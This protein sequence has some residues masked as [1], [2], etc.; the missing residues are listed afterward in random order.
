MHTASQY[1]ETLGCSRKKRFNLSV[2]ERG[3]GRTR[4][5]YF[6][7]YGFRVHKGFGMSYNVKISD[8]SECW[9]KSWAREMKK[10]Y[11]RCHSS[12]R[13]FKLVGGI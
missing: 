11:L 10:L 3:N 7:L 5:L 9:V 1:V 4:Q 12:V 8:W 13:V 6:D 2:P